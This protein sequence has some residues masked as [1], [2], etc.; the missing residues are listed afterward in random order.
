MSN[1]LI[2][3]FQVTEIDNHFLESII[4]ALKYIK[5]PYDCATITPFPP[6]LLIPAFSRRYFT[7]EGSL[8]YPPCTE[9]VKWIIQPEALTISSH[10]LS[11]FRKL[12]G[13]NGFILSN[14]RPVQN[15]NNRTVH[16]YE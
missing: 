13:F 15:I 10:Q 8:T 4:H 14:I 16:F 6:S 3:K 9:G 11:Q 1:F 12:I 2:L 7:Y 5:K